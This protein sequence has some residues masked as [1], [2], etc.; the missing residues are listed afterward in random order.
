MIRTLEDVSRLARE[1][2]PKRLAVLAPEDG[3]FMLAVKKAWEARY[4]EPVLIGDPEKIKRVAAEAAFEIQGIEL[5]SETDRQAVANLGTAMLF[6]GEVDMAGK[7]Q[8][9]TAYIYRAIIKEEAKAGTGRTISVVS[10]WEIPELK[11]FTSFTDTGVNIRPDLKAKVEVVKNAVFVFHVLG[12]ARPRIAVLSGKREIGGSPV[13]FRDAE[14][15]R[16]MAAAGD[17]GECEIVAATCFAEIFSGT[18]GTPQNGNKI[19]ISQLPEIL[20]VPNLD[21]GNILCKLDFFLPVYR[22]SLVTT[23]GGPFI[24]PSRSDFCDSILGEIAMG[25]VVADRIRGGEKR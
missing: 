19:D 7:G 2:G 20:L 21:T 16:K 4:I 17:F 22:R 14:A 18:A 3:E 6:A 10:L 1:K 5:I 25:V 15:L 24:I 8:I 23:S 12:Y 13:S 11:R 9:P